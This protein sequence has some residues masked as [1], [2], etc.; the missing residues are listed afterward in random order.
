MTILF[1]N[2]KT[3]HLSFQSLQNGANGLWAA[4]ASEGAFLGQASTCVTI[5]NLIKLGNTKVLDRYN[6]KYLRKVRAEWDQ[7]EIRMGSEGD[8]NEIRRS[9]GDQNEIRRSE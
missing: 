1:K 6:C 2:I 3:L 8:Q 7:K 9:E 4:V 5:I